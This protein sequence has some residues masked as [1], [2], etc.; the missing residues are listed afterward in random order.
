MAVLDQ[1]DTVLTSEILD[2]CAARAAGYDRDNRFF[3]EDFDELKAAGY[4]L[5]PVPQ[6]FGGAGLTLAEICREQARLACAAPATALAVNM[7][8]CWTGIAADLYGAGDHRLDWMLKEAAAGE[9]F[10]AGHGERGNDLPFSLRPRLPSASRTDTSS[11]A[12]KFSD[13]SRQSYG[14]LWPAKLV[15]AKYRAVEGAKRIVDLAMDVSG[16]TGMFKKNELERLYRDVRCGGFHPANSAIA[17]E[18]VGKSAL[19]LLGEA[20][21]W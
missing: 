10:A 14:D 20:V 5:L 13:R 16:G 2:R 18:V 6:A 19:G 8:L 21:R 1:T 15:S 3:K 7:H 11:P 12:T 17:H 9:V 4:L